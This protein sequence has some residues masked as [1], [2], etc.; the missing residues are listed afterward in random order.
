VLRISAD[1]SNVVHGESKWKLEPR[2]IPFN[3]GPFSNCAWCV[4][5][6]VLI[7]NPVE[8]SLEKINRPNADVIQWIGDQLN[9]PVPDVD[10]EKWNVP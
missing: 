6:V 10:D 9:E 4:L 7:K 1:K 5:I 2:W 8:E 3:N